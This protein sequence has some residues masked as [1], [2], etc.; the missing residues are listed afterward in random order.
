M[1]QY[2]KI[3]RYILLVVFDRGNGHLFA[4]RW[5]QFKMQSASYFWSIDER[6]VKAALSGLFDTDA[7]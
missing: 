3:G 7:F 6:Q 4:D 5:K 2:V 1:S